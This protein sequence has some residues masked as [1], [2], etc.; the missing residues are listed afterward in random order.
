MYDIVCNGFVKEDQVEKSL[1][2]ILK[3][4]IL[5]L[6]FFPFY[7]CR[8]KYGIALYDVALSDCVKK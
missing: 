4:G 3:D 8:T 5:S 2:I 7:Y 1:V 6:P